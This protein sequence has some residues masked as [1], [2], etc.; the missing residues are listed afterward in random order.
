MSGALA[1]CWPHPG[2]TIFTHLN[3]PSQEALGSRPGHWPWL[4]ASGWVLWPL[5]WELG[6]P[7]KHVEKGAFLF[8]FAPGQESFT[9]VILLPAWFGDQKTKTFVVPGDW[10]KETSICCVPVC[11]AQCWAWKHMKTCLFFSTVGFCS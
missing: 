7:G 3:S 2:G 10:R 1:C 4:G 6:R 11:Q 5:P 9:P 8:F